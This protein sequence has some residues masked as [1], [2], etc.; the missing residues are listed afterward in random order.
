MPVKKPL[1]NICRYR[2]KPGKQT[3]MEKLLAVH[4][5]ALHDAGLVTDEKA[6]IYRGLPSARPGGQ[7][8]ADRTY[9]EILIWKDQE[10]PQLAHQL[11]QVMAVWEPMGAICE[12]MDFPNYELLELAPSSG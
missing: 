3:E 8:G 9:I 11:P 10:S 12:E 1:I 2:V 5:S 4:W 7:H 6:R